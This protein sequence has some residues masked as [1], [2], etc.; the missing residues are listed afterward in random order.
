MSAARHLV[1]I[2]DVA[3]MLAGRIEALCAELLRNGKRDGHEWR[4][5]GVDGAP[6]GSLGVHLSGAKA[7]VW[8]DFATGE[9]GD[10]LDLVAAVLFRGDKRQALQ[11]ARA[12]LGLEGADPAMLEVRR[13]EAAA[14]QQQRSAAAEAELEATRNNAFRIW[15]SAAESIAGTPVEAYLRGRGIDLAQL[16]RQPRALRFHP[17]LWNT[18]TRRTWPAMAAAIHD[19]A[20]HFVAVHRT[21]LEVLESG[22]VRKAPLQDAKLTLGSWR[23]GMIRLWRGASGRSLRDARAGEVVDITEGIEDGLS[24]ALS[25]PEARVVAAISLSNLPNLVFP[26]AISGVVLWRQNDTKKAAIAAFDRA[27][28]AFRRRGLMVDI[29]EMPAGLKDVNDMLKPAAPEAV[30]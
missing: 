5:G 1:S 4:C 13:A 2:G 20:G 7:G 6:G 28:T 18:E 17:R 14:A 25:C 29:P 23:G 19:S 15:L 8:A 12:W 26:E 3:S 22:T 10:A 9:T 16:G 21:F 24:V 11:W 27:V 30:A